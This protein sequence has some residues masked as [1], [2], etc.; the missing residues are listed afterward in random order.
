MSRGMSVLCIQNPLGPPP[1]GRTFGCTASNAN[2][3]PSSG[4]TSLS[5]RNI[6]PSCCLPSSSMIQ[7]WMVCPFSFRSTFF[8]VSSW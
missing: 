3:M 8:R 6:M 7:A 4:F 2:S 5:S 1:S